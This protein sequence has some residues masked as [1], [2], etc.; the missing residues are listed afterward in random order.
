MSFF[1]VGNLL[2][3][4]IVALTLIIFRRS[5]RGPMEK[6]RRYGE[7]LKDQLAEFVAQK[8]AAVRDYGVALD[9][10]QK[11]AKELM[12]RLQ[13]SEEAMAAKIA[14]VTDLNEKIK[15]YDSTL[16]EL[17]RMTLRVQVNLTRIQE[18]SPFVE[19][20][21]KKVTEAK[22]KL[23][24]IEKGLVDL[25]LHFDRENALSLEKASASMIAAV[26]STV[27]DLQVTAETIER[28]VEDHR[29][30]IDRI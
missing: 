14:T 11:Q 15:T 23:S 22:E 8:E 5:D 4:G 25:E 6:A 28:R 24:S 17:V 7:K 21:G 3:L 10:R 13:F 26:E 18:E 30:A 27:S 2:T 19:G 29:D 1:T 12:N 16:G 20:V 9:V